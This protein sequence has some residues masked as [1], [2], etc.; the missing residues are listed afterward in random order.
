MAP[1]LRETPPAQSEP[2]HRMK[3]TENAFR[4]GRYKQPQ[5]VNKYLK[6]LAKEL[7][8]FAGLEVQSGKSH[9]QITELKS[10][11]LLTVYCV[12]L[13]KTNVEIKLHNVWR[14]EVK[15]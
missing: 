6:Y 15:Y 10:L 8:S 7:F 14:K 4:L 12:V 2:L 9:E 13:V 5:K 3:H 11:V 1:G